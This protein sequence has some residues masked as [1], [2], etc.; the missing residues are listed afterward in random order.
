M[1]RGRHLTAGRQVEEIPQAILRP[2][3]PGRVIRMEGLPLP[4]SLRGKPPILPRSGFT[5]GMPS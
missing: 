1:C 2:G 3:K 4:G 5:V